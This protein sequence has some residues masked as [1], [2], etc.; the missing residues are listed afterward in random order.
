[1]TQDVLSTLTREQREAVRVLIARAWY[2]G[3]DDVDEPAGGVTAYRPAVHYARLALPDPPKRTVTRPRVEVFDEVKW[4]VVDGRQECWKGY[5]EA[6]RHGEYGPALA[7]HD[8]AARWLD[9]WDN[10]TE[11]VEV[12]DDA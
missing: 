8:D 5:A 2:D 3:N 12:D 6:W 4:R 9:L 11:T 7:T 10:P 1:M